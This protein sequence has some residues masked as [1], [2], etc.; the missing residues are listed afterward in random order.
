MNNISTNKLSPNTSFLIVLMGSL[1]DVARGLC[2]AT[3]IKKHL[4]GSKVTWLIEPKWV[5]LVDVHPHIDNVIVFN[6]ALN[7]FGVFGLRKQ[8]KKQ[9]FDIV[10]DLQRHLKSGFFSF[11]SGAKRR[12]GFHRK[13]TKELNWIF[14]N[15]RIECFGETIPKFFHYLKFIEHLGLPEAETIDFG[16]SSLDTDSFIPD[17]IV[18]M[19]RPYA[20]VILF[21]EHYVELIRNILSSGRASVVLLGDCSK[22]N[23]SRSIVQQVDSPHVVNM[24]NQTSLLE[25]VAILRKAS[26]AVGPDSGPGH[27]SAA[28]GTPYVSLFGPTPPFR[29][30]PYACENLVVQTSADCAP[31]NKKKC[32][33]HEDHCMR[34]ITARE[35]FS[36][37]D[38]LLD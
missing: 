12:I 22:Q 26:A 30:A 18:A 7:A 38:Q 28:V 8:M 11:L 36:K 16:L 2:V 21:L 10:L 32:D 17:S 3:H 34:L 25:L 19:D 9:H 29:V 37:L 27:L 20:A 1:G 5:A 14:N 24:V 4:P 35:V 33:D 23:L 13:D 6:R 31:C 15:D